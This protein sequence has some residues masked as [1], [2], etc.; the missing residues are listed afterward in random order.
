MSTSVKRPDN[1]GQ[2]LIELVVM[3]PI[4]LLVMATVLP[5]VAN[6]VILPLL[7][8]RLTLR[9]LSEEGKRTHQILQI[10]HSDNHLPPYFETEKLQET[11]EII[12]QGVPLPLIGRIF[13][14]DMTRKSI[15][16][17]IPIHGWWNRELLASPQERHRE[18]SRDLTILADQ[19]LPESSVPEEV[20]KLTSIGV[21]SSIAGFLEKTGLNLFHLNLDALPKKNKEKK[22]RK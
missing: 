19:L 6:G 1:K 12:Q 8:E 7:D 11:T 5:I 20:K 21:V 14:S 13:S 17:A 9:H 22:E 16:T 2:A 10:T 18:I 15:K 4:L 3:L